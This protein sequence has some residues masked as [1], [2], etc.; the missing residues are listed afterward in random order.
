MIAAPRRDAIGFLLAV[1]AVVFFV[2]LCL[3]CSADALR[4]ACPATCYPGPD[5][6]AG[7]GQCVA[8]VPGCDANGHVL[9][10]SGYVVPAN[11][12]CNGSDDDCNG[13]A[14]DYPDVPDDAGCLRLGACAG[15]VPECI[16]GGWV[17][18][19]GPNVEMPEETRCDG[20]DNDCDG[21]VD[22]D[23]F[24]GEYCYSGPIGTEATAPCHP[25]VMSC[26]HGEPACVNEITPEPD[27]CDG[28]DNDCDGVVDENSGGD[29]SYDIVL[30]VDVSGSMSDKL[31]AV[32]G[33]LDAYM[34]QFA[35]DT[36]RR[37]ALVEMGTPMMPYY[38]LIADLGDVA[39]ARAALSTAAAN[40]AI[41]PVIDALF[42]ICGP[43]DELAISWTPGA[44]RVVLIWGDEM[45]QTMRNMPA[46][47]A[48]AACVAT[49]SLVYT[50]STL[51][52]FSDLS[53][54]SGGHDFMIVAD[55]DAMLADLNAVLSELCVAA[56]P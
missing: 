40:G 21:R 45:M 19:Y 37:W 50:W 3:S 5:G 24:A 48:N 46:T 10:C 39:T 31:G 52:Y 44:R 53:D 43:S 27:V 2:G 42:A 25:G 34:G 47:D 13:L 35:T 33:A 20:I 9:S 23:L 1:V 14:D 41:E 26:V 29:T 54:P 49:S 32:A 12:V 7:V 30:L 16:D 11:E 15:A 22:E 18:R 55:T 28:V 38:R 36:T 6:T 4:P 51:G 8:G 56:S 17:C